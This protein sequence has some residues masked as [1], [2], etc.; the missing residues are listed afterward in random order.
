HAVD[1]G[2]DQHR[3]IGLLDIVGS[4]ALQH[5][6]EQIELAV[7]LGVAG[8]RGIGAGDVEDG[9]CAGEAG[10]DHEDPKREVGFARHPCT[11]REASDHQG[12][13]SMGRW[14]F[15]NSTWRT[16]PPSCAV[17]DLTAELITPTGSPMSTD[18]PTCT[19]IWDSPASKI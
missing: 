6:S 11:F 4:H 14:S 16:G 13:G 2:V 3:V 5:V 7:D 15:R 10:H 17:C 18:W 19:S 12:S 8:C 9:G 1:R